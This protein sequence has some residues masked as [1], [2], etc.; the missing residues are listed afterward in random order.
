VLAG[1]FMVMGLLRPSRR[2]AALRWATRCG[3]PH[4][5]RL[6]AS[7]CAFVGHWV[8]RMRTLGFHRPDDLRANVLIE[9]AEHLAAAPGAAILLGF[10]LGPSDGDLTFRVLGYPVTLLGGSDRGA[11]MTWWSEA[12][13]PFVR[14]S[15][16]SFAAGDR[17]RWT[18]VLYMGRRILLEGEKVY[19]L[20]D[21]DGREAFRLQLSV[22]EMPIRAGWITLHQLTGVPVLPVL[23]R[24]DGRRQVVAIHPPLP[25]FTSESPDGLDECREHLTR[26]V[27]DYVRRFP[28]QCPHLALELPPAYR[29]D[30]GTR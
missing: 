25:A 22:G 15:E 2:R 27:D 6:A 3:A 5:W 4:R 7:L 24:L 21:G 13:R 9:G 20:A 18:A 19:I 16:L 12:W 26:L 8:A 28:E 1:L 14:R 17:D 29:W 10:H 23:R 30:R 11:T